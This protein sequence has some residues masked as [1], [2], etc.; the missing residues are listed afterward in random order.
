MS[1]SQPEADVHLLT[2]EVEEALERIGEVDILVGIPS[3]NNAKTIGHVLRAVQGGLIKYFPEFRSIVVNSDG[4][5]FDGTQEIARNTTLDNVHQILLTHRVLHPVHRIVT[6]YHGIP[7]KGSAFRTI[8]AIAKRLHARAC[9]VVD[10]DLRSITPEWMELLI[11]PVLQG[12][13]DYV[14]PYYL[15]HKY[16]GT[17]TNN[18]IYPLT[19]ALY[20]RRI[21]QPIGG[22]FGFSG[23]LA[24]CYLTRPVWHTDVA[25]YGI[26]IWMTTTALAEGYKI[27]QVF[28]GAKIHD[29]KDPG[30]HL[31]TMMVQVVGSLFSLM[32]TYEESWQVERELRPVPLLGFSHD[33]GLEPINVN[34]GRMLQTFRQ[35]VKDLQPVWEEILTPPVL[36]GVVQLDQQ[37]DEAFF[38]PE[39]LW[40]QVVYDF[41]VAYHHRVLN[42]DHLLRS[43]TPL[44]LARTASFVLETKTLSTAQAEEKIELL[45]EEFVRQRPYLIKHWFGEGG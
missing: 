34:V 6:P 15:R 32:E 19:A 28:L 18:I 22:D 12:D 43:L 11:R 5:S 38:F 4:G 8:F 37:A 30:L 20:G 23:E 26:D 36:E 24:A 39:S 14:C 25:R 27:C 33:V 44:Y 3:Y 45:C 29:P 35:A 21:R 13:F 2:P 17:I 10:A 16:D 42:R 1:L 31:A 7:G 9:A 40:V 41:A